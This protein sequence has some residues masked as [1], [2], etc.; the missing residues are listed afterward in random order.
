L[1]AQNKYLIDQGFTRLKRN[2]KY[3]LKFDKDQEKALAALKEKNGKHHHHKK[4]KYE[5]CEE[6]EKKWQ[7]KLEKSKFQEQHTYLTSKGFTNL[8]RNFKKLEKFNGDKD[9]A[10]EALLKREEK[11]KNRPSKEEKEKN[12]AEEILKLGYFAQNQALVAKGF[13]KINRNLKMLI[14]AAGDVDATL[15]RVSDKEEKRQ[16]RKKMKEDISPEEKA[17]KRFERDEKKK[18]KEELKSWLQSELKAEAKI[19]YLDGNNML[20]V[21]D[22]IRKLCL[23]HKGK[24]AEK[25]IAD[26]AMEIGKSLGIEQIVLIFDRTKNVYSQT[27]GS[28]KFS[29]CSASPNFKTSDDALVDW[30]GG[31]SASINNILIVTSDVGL[32]IRLKEKGVKMIMKSGAWFK[33]LQAKLGEEVYKKIIDVGTVDINDVD[34]KNLNINK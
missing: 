30:M 8:R 1:T 9:K 13:T 21:D 4:G 3:L 18:L 28:L 6:K 22:K 32:Q 29:V 5:S 12:A 27:F 23:K 20:F 16:L 31:L 25:L 10:L 17:K 11:Y 34:L 7:E 26:L 19:V 33:V 15:K 2:L 14:K 24:Q